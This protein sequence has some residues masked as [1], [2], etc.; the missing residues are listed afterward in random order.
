M[1]RH[2]SPSRSSP[3]ISNMH[4]DDGG[5]RKVWI[6][7]KE[8]EI[9]PKKFIDNDLVDTNSVILTLNFEIVHAC[10]LRF[11]NYELSLRIASRIIS[12]GNNISTK[13]LF[14]SSMWYLTQMKLAH[15]DDVSDNR[16]YCR[17]I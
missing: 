3:S 9:E 17:V 8:T 14:E 5:L 13:R 12:L 7:D 2:H 6:M 15:L 16:K 11:D 10:I 1:I 4:W